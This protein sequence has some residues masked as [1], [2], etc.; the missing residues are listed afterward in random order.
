MLIDTEKSIWTEKEAV[1]LYLG[2]VKFEITQDTQVFTWG[3]ELKFLNY[4][5][6]D[7]T[8]GEIGKKTNGKCFIN[9]F[10]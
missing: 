3:D 4:K 9:I 6:L 5:N 2:H 1:E 10:G 8:Q 7:L